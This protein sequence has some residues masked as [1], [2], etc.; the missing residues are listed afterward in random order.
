MTPKLYHRFILAEGEERFK[1]IP[2][3]GDDI[4]CRIGSVEQ[5]CR[6]GKFS[7]K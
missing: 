6:I 5:D 3:P 2:V 4:F 7:K 1:H